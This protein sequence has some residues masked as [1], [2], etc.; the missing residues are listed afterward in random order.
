MWSQMSESQLNKSQI[1]VV[2]K[3]S[4]RAGT[5]WCCEEFLPEFSQTC[6]KS[7][8]AAL[9]TNFLLQRSWRSFF[10]MNTTK[11]SSW[12]FL[13]KL[14][15]IF[16]RIFGDCAQIFKD[17]AR[18]FDKSK[19]WGVLESPAPRLLRHWSQMNESQIS[20]SRMN[21]VSNEW[22]QMSDLNW[23]VSNEGVSIVCTPCPLDAFTIFNDEPFLCSSKTHLFHDSNPCLCLQTRCKPL[24]AV[25]RQ[26]GSPVSLK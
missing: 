7:F 5:F 2:S 25:L 24:A 12:V 9:P 15:A 23:V 14:G 13:Q 8:S 4:V 1:N 20:R 18:I 21:M 26:F 16:S 11:R 17:F 19:L 3:I 10:G 22:S 6:P